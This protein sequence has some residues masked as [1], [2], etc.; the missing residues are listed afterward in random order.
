MPEAKPQTRILSGNFEHY[1]TLKKMQEWLRHMHSR[2]C[3]C[4]FPI[5]LPNLKDPM[6]DFFEHE[7]QGWGQ[8]SRPTEYLEI[9]PL[10]QI[11]KMTKKYNNFVVLYSYRQV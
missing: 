2:L 7:H 6:D 8:P 1:I 3:S 9:Q 11:T 4:L 5:V 10:K